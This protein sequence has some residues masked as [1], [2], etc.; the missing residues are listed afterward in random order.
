MWPISK[1]IELGCDRFPL[2]TE[3]GGATRV[4][5]R[6]LRGIRNIFIVEFSS[7]PSLSNRKVSAIR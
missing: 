7:L 4:L 6:F 1:Y 5:C 2:L 3:L